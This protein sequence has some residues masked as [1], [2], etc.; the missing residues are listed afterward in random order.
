MTE[1]GDLRGDL[2]PELEA[3]EAAALGQ[4]A[5]RLQTQRPVPR[6]SFRGD[7]RRW[8]LNMQGPRPAPPRVRILIAASGGAGAA[9]LL[10]AAASV[11]GA[12]PLA[13]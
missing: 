11:A 1:P 12:G 8:L 7:L 9:L 2:T 10:V 5:E 3:G 4:I 13:A 6:P